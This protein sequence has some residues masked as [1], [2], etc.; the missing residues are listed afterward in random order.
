MEAQKAKGAKLLPYG[1]EFW[2]RARIVAGGTCQRF[3]VVG[4]DLDIEDLVGNRCGEAKENRGG[5]IVACVHGDELMDR[6]LR[7]L[8]EDIITVAMGAT[9][10]DGKDL[11]GE[12]GAVAGRHD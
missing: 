10:D 8:L 4:Q 11:R 12:A 7:V 9:G 3:D 6:L 2:G 1:I 5:W